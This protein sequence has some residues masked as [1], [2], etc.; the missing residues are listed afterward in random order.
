MQTITKEQQKIINLIKTETQENRLLAYRLDTSQNAGVA[1]I[2]ERVLRKTNYWMYFASD[3][4]DSY[5]YTNPPFD[6]YQNNFENQ[7][8]EL[9]F[10]NNETP[11]FLEF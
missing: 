6:Y 11:L 2:Y 5:M 10:F 8:F 9:K 1:A 7:L 3:V 4:D